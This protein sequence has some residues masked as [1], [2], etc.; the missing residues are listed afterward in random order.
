METSIWSVLGMN[1]LPHSLSYRHIMNTQ[2]IANNV[3]LYESHYVTAKKYPK[4]L[5]SPLNKSRLIPCS[6]KQEVVLSVKRFPHYEIWGHWG[7]G[8]FTGI[9]FSGCVQP[10]PVTLG[11]LGVVLISNYC[12]QSR[13]H[14]SRK[15][16]HQKRLACWCCVSECMTCSLVIF[17]VC[18]PL[19][20][21]ITVAEYPHFIY[22][23][24]TFFFPSTH[25]M[26]KFNLEYMDVCH[27]AV[28]A[29]VWVKTKISGS[30]TGSP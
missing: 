9:V 20:P 14:C 8:A 23:N 22:S 13:P 11:P 12:N 4:G 16:L 18:L 7:Q 2:P 17:S 19:L 5:K 28:W 29:P 27:P 6:L 3:P 15:A 25:H 21:V 26:V 1:Y 30:K 24:S 10:I